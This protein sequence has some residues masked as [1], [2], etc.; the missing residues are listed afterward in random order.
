VRDREVEP[1]QGPRRDYMIR[2]EG[3]VARDV[4]EILAELALWVSDA[5]APPRRR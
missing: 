1:D 2:V 5:V 4:E 3:P